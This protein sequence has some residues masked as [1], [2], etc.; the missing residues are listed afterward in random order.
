MPFRRPLRRELV[1]GS[2]VLV[3]IASAALAAWLRAD[4]PRRPCCLGLGAYSLEEPIAADPRLR[5]DTLA[6]GLRYYIR[7]NHPPGGRA[8]GP[9]GVEAGSRLGGEERPGC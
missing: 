5:S 4:P 8:Q 2:V 3:C 7:E 1:A 6:N 9:P